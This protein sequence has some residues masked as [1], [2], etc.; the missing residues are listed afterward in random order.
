MR[1][2]REQ[3]LVRSGAHRAA[4]AQWDRALATVALAVWA[5]RMPLAW[6]VSSSTLI[7]LALLPIWLPAV[8]RYRWAP[9]LLILASVGFVSGLFLTIAQSATR[10]IS[11]QS[12]IAQ[13]SV[14]IAAFGGIGLILWAREHLSDGKV[15]MVIG[16]T[17]LVVNLPR[18][19]STTNDWKYIY[20]TPLT[21]LVLGYFNRRRWAAVAAL[22]VFGL[23]GAALD[24]RSYFGMCLLAAGVLLLQIRRQRAAPGWPARLTA[25]GVGAMMAVA[26][27]SMASSLLAGGY[28]GEE[29]GAR[30]QEQ[31]ARTGS[32]L[33]SGRPEWHGTV[34]L[35]RAHPAGFGL[36]AVP[37]YDDIWTA[38]VGLVQAGVSVDNHYVDHYMFDGEFKFHSVAG[39]LWS[40][41]GLLGLATALLIL[42][43]YAVGLVDLVL[44]GRAGAVAVY[45][46][47]LGTWDLAFS[48]LYGSWRFMALA[49]GLLLIPKSSRDQVVG[50]N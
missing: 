32:L 8:P 36:G 40:Q 47:I 23:V 3:R 45:L 4:D 33:T 49:V 24:S 38:R 41:L 29:V 11:F 14:V 43:V 6:G 9:Q 1:T 12:M 31:I 2:A 25:I 46:G 37:S 28:L 18:F 21:I 15:A 5:A 7:V 10:A 20:A 44:S 35:M 19:G 17:M 13:S 22:G 39:D 27:Y 26:I 42:A 16:A 34:E 50:A 48:P 30:T